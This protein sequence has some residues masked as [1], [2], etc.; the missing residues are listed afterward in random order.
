[1]VAVNKIIFSTILLVFSFN[2]FCQDK[3]IEPGRY[4]RTLS[5]HGSTE[6][7]IFSKN[8]SIS[9]SK[10]MINRPSKEVCFGNYFVKEDTLF[11]NYDKDSIPFTPSYKVVK[12]L[13]SKQLNSDITI[14][15]EVFMNIISCRNEDN[16]K[17]YAEYDSVI[18][19]NRVNIILLDSLDNTVLNLNSFHSKV[20]L[21]SSRK[22]T[23]EVAAAGTLSS[24]K[25][26]LNEFSSNEVFLELM[27]FEKYDLPCSLDNQMF[28]ILEITKNSIFFKNIDSGDITTY[29]KS[30]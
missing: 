28:L 15:L 22:S 24:T 29:Y 23:I 2:L 26:S 16:F 8:N 20:I 11:V 6:T 25:I 9:F 10:K 4:D 5:T 7:F 1:M 14:H 19:A 13:D 12:E 30:N 3:E 17:K 21:K 18:P 27:T